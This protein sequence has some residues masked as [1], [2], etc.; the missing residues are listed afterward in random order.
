M[1]NQEN[2]ATIKT[3]N[4]NSLLQIGL[5]AGITLTLFLYLIFP[6]FPGEFD[7]FAMQLS[8]A[9]QI[10][11]IIGLITCFPAIV[12]LYAV[13]PKSKKEINK[14]GLIK[15]KKLAK[16]YVWTF[17]IVFLPIA[18]MTAITVSLSFGIGLF[19]A[20]V[21]SAW[22]ILQKITQCH[23]GTLASL[24]L[25]LFLILLPILLLLFQKVVD[26]PL[27]DWSRN[28]T[29]QKSKQLIDEIENYQAKYGKYP[30]TLNAVN[31]DYN[32]GIRGIEK[33][34][35]TY[36]EVTYNLYFEQP[37]FLWDKF[38]TREFL[39]Y[40]PKDNHLLISHASWNARWEPQQIRTTQGWYTSGN[41]IHPHWK[42]F[43]FD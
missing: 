21:I 18:L 6:F 38:G 16:I 7:A 25:P 13:I 8:L 20:I 23:S 34:H 30:L 11:S 19:I 4:K 29:I 28:K 37:K 35:Y 26:K 40:N 39:V 10:F 1:E 5:M 22:F 42:Y 3:D 17:L 24:P 33:Y 41:T 9:I 2:V 43:L 32:T 15:S 27:T 36:D 14:E 31:R 12:W